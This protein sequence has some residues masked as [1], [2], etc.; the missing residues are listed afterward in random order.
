[1]SSKD[2]TTHRTEQEDIDKVTEPQARRELAHL[3]LKIAFH[4]RQYHQKDA[5]EISDAAY[6]ALRKRNDSLEKK[7]PH[8]IREDSPS[9]RVG[10]NC[11][12]GF[13]KITHTKPMLSLS[14]AFHINDIHDFLEKIKRFLNFKEETID[15]WVEPKID[16]LSA[17]IL[18]REGR[19]SHA[20]TRGDG[21]IGEDVTI[22]IRT[23]PSIPHS[24]RGNFPRI[25]EIRG[26]VYMN[27]EDFIDLNVEQQRA[28]L[29][30]FSNPRNAAA[31]SLRQL[32]SK[33]TAQR[34]LS[35]FAY[36]WGE[37]SAPFAP[38]MQK[39]NKKLQAWGF[40]TPP[41]A[42]IGKTFEQVKTLY[43][44]IENARAKVNFDM[45][46]VV[47]K[48]NQLDLQ[49][50][51]GFITRTPRW[52]IALKFPA[53]KG[54]T[55]L[56]TITIQV[57]RTGALTPVANLVP[58]TIGGVTL[59]RATLHNKD[60]IIRKDI[61]EGDTVIVQR[62]GDVIPQ[63]IEVIK[64]Q[65][66]KNAIPYRFPIHCPACGS[67][68]IQ[69]KDTV[70]IRCSGG[71]TTCPAQAI[72][73]I[74]HFISRNAFDIE[75]FGTKQVEKFF[76]DGLLKT[77]VDIFYLHNHYDKII[78]RDGWGKQSTDNLLQAIEDKRVIPFDRF[79]FALGI[80]EVG[81]STAKV[82]AKNYTDMATLQNIAEKA[83]ISQESSA[84]Q[85]MKNMDQ[86]GSSI[87]EEIVQF[88]T[89]TDN[90]RLVE[91]LLSQITIV[92]YTTTSIKSPLTDKIVVFTGTLP[93]I[94]RKEAKAIA[95]S[96]GAKVTNSVSQKT[97]FLICEN[98][99][100]SKAQKAQELGI[101][102]LSQQQFMNMV[103]KSKQSSLT[104]TI[105]SSKTIRD[106]QQK[107]P[108]SIPKSKKPK[109]K[110]QLDLL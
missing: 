64:Q 25:V 9:K 41:L 69:K 57:G 105:D 3:A 42:Q 82:L 27:K 79:L 33:I 70:V 108:Y 92:P 39:A 11:K 94:K 48:V 8:L 103:K 21:K 49:Q 34:K 77:Y 19:L 2:I 47:C 73:G 14:N 35:F 83:N 65:R 16:G 59:T 51:L 81:Y 109:I 104:K 24:L 102:I 53:Q 74:K 13:K 60:E 95:E 26:E 88:F 7:F 10:Y 4:D 106:T 107:N 80:R 28:G 86:V 15:L 6:D 32:D 67:P 36:S 97:H 56:R 96:L 54:R 99:T 38:T 78:Q 68:V 23:I 71:S 58:I 18:Y 100:S 17:A 5:P 20:V 72:E 84:Y 63:I 43:E 91:T 46:G 52:A 87:V 98:I 22:N 110:V 75:G 62:A 89:N 29:K 50:R 12:K 61:R 31:G 90:K 85:D 101:K 30:E 45:D 1:M 93:Q 40:K 37:T 66:N 55:K 76:K 44:K